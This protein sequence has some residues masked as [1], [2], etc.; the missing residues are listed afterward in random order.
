MELVI[1][2]VICTRNRG[3]ILPIALNSVLTQSLP[4]SNYEV[5]LIDNGS[6]DKTKIIVREFQKVNSHLSYHYEPIVGLSNARNRGWKEAKAPYIAYTDDDCKLPNNWLK[7]ASSIIK[8]KKPDIFGGPY[9]PFY[10]TKKPDWFKDEYQSMEISDKA[11]ELEDWGFL[12]GGNLFVKKSILYLAGGFNP[13]LG[14]TGKK[15]AYGEETA[16]I[17]WIRKNYPDKII[18]YDPNLFVYHLVQDYRMDFKWL[19]KQRF[20][21]GRY[22][23]RIFE[24]SVTSINHLAG[25]F[26]VP[27]IILFQLT[28]GLLFRNKTRYPYPQ[29]HIFEKVLPLVNKYG[30]LYERFFNKGND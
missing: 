29:N 5:I 15:I 14:M 13:Y 1:S 22:S 27:L 10:I 4:Q 28:I 17:L 20:V 30:K 16:L 23:Q 18:Y 7:I 6:E 8:D 21:G 3:A 25:L 24:E 2:V 19:F 11:I 12:S 9:Y 26:V